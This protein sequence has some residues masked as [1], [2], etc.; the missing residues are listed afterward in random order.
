MKLS[1]TLS[2][3]R[4]DHAKA[5]SGADKEHS[6]SVE[7]SA[8]FSIRA[9]PLSR[10]ISRKVLSNIESRVSG[11][12]QISPFKICRGE[13]TSIS[14]T[15]NAVKYWTSSSSS[16]WGNPSAVGLALS[17]HGE[18]QSVLHE[19]DFIPSDLNGCEGVADDHE[20]LEVFDAGVHKT[21]EEKYPQSRRKK[22]S[23]ESAHLISIIEFK[24]EKKNQKDQSCEKIESISR[25]S[26]NFFIQ[27]FSSQSPNLSRNGSHFHE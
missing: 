17:S 12:F 15:V 26:K 23:G 21:V 1:N 13:R 18:I 2:K 22:K 10:E 5:Q 14:Y 8:E 7:N 4:K 6:F 9:N 20:F 24:E 11:F 16:A 19:L 3:D 25:R 27:S